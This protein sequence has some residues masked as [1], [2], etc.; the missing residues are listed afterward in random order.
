[1]VAVAGEDGPLSLE[2]RSFLGRLPNN[3]K[4]C[5]AMTAVN[6]DW[7]TDA[8]PSVAGREQLRQ[9]DSGGG[10]YG[11][12]SCSNSAP[13]TLIALPRRALL[14]TTQLRRQEVVTCGERPTEQS[15]RWPWLHRCFSGYARTAQPSL[16]AQPVIV[17]QRKDAPQALY[18]S[19][20][21]TPVAEM[22]VLH[23]VRSMP[24][25]HGFTLDFS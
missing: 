21:M 16:Q 22:T 2:K 6:I 4:A 11:V 1:M 5:K 24:D 20:F 3:I 14:Y 15:I 23:Q 18:G 25:C 7:T 12:Y 19:G 9:N 10:G 13:I 17:A 8:A